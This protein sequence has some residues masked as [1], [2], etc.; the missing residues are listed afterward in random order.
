M[1]KKTFTVPNIT[2]QHCI[3]SIKNELSEINGVVN[4]TGDPQKKTIT[5]EWNPPISEQIIRNTLKEIN[6]PAEL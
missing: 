2:C 1:E 5:V 3:R 4:V 6:Y